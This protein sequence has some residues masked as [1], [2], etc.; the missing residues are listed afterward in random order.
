LIDHQHRKYVAGEDP[1]RRRNTCPQYL[2]RVDERK[3]P[4]NINK[5]YFEKI[6]IFFNIIAKQA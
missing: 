3:T 6:N 1:A 5:P 2:R 4:T